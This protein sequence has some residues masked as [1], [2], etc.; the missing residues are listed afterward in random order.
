M[1]QR[2]HPLQERSHETVQ[3]IFDAASRLLVRAPVEEITTSRIAQEADISVGAL[4]R[5]FP[6]KQAIL[7]GLAVKH[8]EEFKTSAE[9]RLT[10]INM[11]DGPAFLSSVIDIYVAFLDANPDFRALAFG[12]HI[13]QVTRRKE[14]DPVAGGASL[15]R[16]FMLESLGMSNVAQLDLRL[17]I[18]METGERLMGFAYQHARKS[19]RKEIIE[20]LKR[21]LSRYLFES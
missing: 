10:G 18:A 5:F 6:G 2:R 4:Y 14:T 21:L 9:T 1:Q 3:R 13:S 11:D 12:Q 16:R 19:E 20:E 17:R 8:L 15:V 7:D